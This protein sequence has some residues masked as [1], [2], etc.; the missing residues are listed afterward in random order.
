M[1]FIKADRPPA[2]VLLT[3]AEAG[4]SLAILHP[5]HSMLPVFGNDLRL[6]LVFLISDRFPGGV[7][8]AEDLM[9]QANALG[10]QQRLV[11]HW[12]RLLDPEDGDATP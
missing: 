4:S 10:V 2:D 6:G 8:G 9:S 5:N 7:E 1:D 3:S 11:D 12:F